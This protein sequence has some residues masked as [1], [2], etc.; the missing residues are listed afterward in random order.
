[1]LTQLF[2]SL[3]NINSDLI[4]KPLYTSAEV[5]VCYDIYKKKVQNHW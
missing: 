2:D 5:V 4:Y 1:M 3:N